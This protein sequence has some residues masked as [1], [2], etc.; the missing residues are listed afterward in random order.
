MFLSLNSA[1]G[2]AEDLIKENL[3]L[4]ARQVA[5]RT[6]YTLVSIESDLDVMGDLPPEDDAYVTFSL[7]QRREL[8]SLVKQERRMETVPKYREVAFYAADGL[9]G[10]VVVDDQPVRRP[11]RFVSGDNRWCETEDFVSLALE[12]PGR[13]L[14]TG[15]IGCHLSEGRYLPA[16]GRLGLRFSGGIRVS[17]ALVAKNGRVRGVA[18]L[19]LSQLHLV[20]AIESLQPPEEQEESHAWGMMVD[21]EGWVI[22]HPDPR[23]TA[24]RNRD[25]N[26]VAGEGWDDSKSVNLT[27][28]PMPVG[29]LFAALLARAGQGLKGTSA[30]EER[31]RGDW[32][33]AAHPIQAEIGAYG[34]EEPFGTVL[35]LYPRAKALEAVTDLRWT[36]AALIG[37][38]LLLVM[39]GSAALAGNISRPI[40][41]L[42]I[43]AKSLGRGEPRQVRMDRGDEIGELAQAFDRMQSDL[44][45][46]R[47]ALLRA[48]R[49]A[50]IGRF[51]SGIVHETKNVLA[52]LG[53][54]VSLLER[55]APDDIRDK[56]LPPMKRALDQMDNLVVRLRELSLQPRFAQTDLVSVLQHTVELV[57]PQAREKGI[58]L[59]VDAPGDLELP[60]GDASLLGQVFLNLLV[61]ALEATPEK[62]RIVVSARAD[63]QWMVVRVKDTGPGLPEVT[64]ER[65]LEPFFTTKA[66]GTGLGLYIS[67]S[68]V[69]RHNGDC[70]LENHPDGGAVAQVRLPIG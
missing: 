12:D 21:R 48:E 63:G 4:Q 2:V 13:T 37:L 24:G 44:E 64:H 65:L 69:E 6:S 49:L 35:I 51:V 32:L 62:G 28:L 15:L 3:M 29:G 43:A 59:L 67:A 42:V 30:I 7:S 58:V 16:E 19:V 70:T 55:K 11:T 33:V 25:G 38:T 8:Y 60:R 46:S 26:L 23:F 9:P 34:A 54:Y 61:N 20:W 17:K 18:T 50:A 53:N 40:R 1:V 14:V 31:G 39:I 22:A 5:Q 66:G 27:G 47:E 57:E 45:V 10:T 36:F 68:I 52:G 41:E 56:V